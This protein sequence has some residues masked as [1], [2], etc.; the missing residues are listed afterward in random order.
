MM[1]EIIQPLEGPS[2][3][4]DF[5][6]QHGEGLHHV[7]VDCNGIPWDDR[8]RLFREHGYDVAQSGVWQGQVRYAYF[9]TEGDIA[10][11][12]ETALFP[13]GFTM[14]EPERRLPSPRP[15]ST[16]PGAAWG[17]GSSLLDQPVPRRGEAGLAPLR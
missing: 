3:Y 17:R 4:T 13:D 10:T 9:M 15:A 6:E 2:I 11:T 14:A 7:L 1:W 12:I 16:C 8:V 5:L